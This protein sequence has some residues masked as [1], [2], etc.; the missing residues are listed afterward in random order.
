MLQKNTYIFI[1][2]LIVSLLMLLPTPA[3]AQYGKKKA[4]IVEVPDTVPFFNGLSVSYDLFGTGQMIFVDY[5]QY[6]GA[7]RANLRDRYFPILEFGFG[8]T[9]KTDAATQTYYKTSAPYVRLGVDYNLMK[10]KHDKYRLYGGVRYGFT[11]FKFDVS[12]PYVHDP[13]WGRPADYAAYGVKAH[14]H[15]LEAAFGV[16]ATIMGP[17]KLGWSIRYRNRLFHGTDEIDNAWYVPGFGKAGTSNIGATFNAIFE[18]P[19]K[20]KT[21]NEN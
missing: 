6:E 15:W 4:K 3:L 17:F 5:G 1:S 11:N 19:I 9:E 10:N 20:K 2:S 21:K 14:Y 16:E 18:L 13:I 7:V 12:N 8:K